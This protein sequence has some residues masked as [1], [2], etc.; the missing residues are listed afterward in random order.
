MT[1]DAQAAAPTVDLDPAR[2]VGDT[3]SALA[4][5]ALRVAA[6]FFDS[7]TSDDVKARETVADKAD[8]CR[9]LADV[10]VKAPLGSCRR[11]MTP[12]TLGGRFFTLTEQTWSNA[13]VAAYLLSDT[14]QIMENLPAADG[15][16]KNQLLQTAQRLRRVEVLV[17]QAPNAELGPRL[18]QLAPLLRRLQR[19]SDGERP[20]SSHLIDGTTSNP[21]FWAAAQ[22]VY[23]IVAGRELDDLPAQVQAVWSGKLAVAWHRHHD[24]ARPM[25]EVELE[26]LDHATRHPA[27]AWSRA[28][29]S[30]GDWSDLSPETAASVLRLI[31]SRF[32][33][34]PS[35]TP[36]PLAAFCDRVR[37]RPLRCYDGAVLVET[38]GR[39]AGGAAGIAT[40][41]ITDDD[42]HA[43][44]GTSVWI[45]DLNETVGPQLFDE[46]ARLDYIRLF[47]NL[48]RNDG[49][50]F[51]LAESFD[52]LADRATDVETLRTLCVDHTATP[53]PAGFDDEGRW[54]YVAEIAYGE[55]LFVAVLA[56]TPNG[57]L[58][59][60]D[61]EVLIE[62]L[63]LRSEHMDGL[64]VVLNGKGPA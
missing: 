45:H 22:D 25:T 56:L 16:L 14:A 48:V 55:A 42:I 1:S 31:G 8:T 50:R 44:D 26:R 40:F 23:R 32:H 58:E 27:A 7:M 35:A 47:M 57:M 37:S 13:E 11:L 34:G 20:I 17:R 52:V 15:A 41:L 53:A 4:A 6:A 9:R 43:A 24:R 19:P 54:R 2:R 36:L 60:T 10:I 39:L 5:D 18:D 33:M 61:D 49:E 30:P 59:M 29:L 64:F 62:N 12:N 63:P 46:E 3:V 28:P 21:E 51:Q 38:Q